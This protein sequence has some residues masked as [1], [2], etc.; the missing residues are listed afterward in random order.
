MLDINP[1]DIIF[2]KINELLE[3]YY[4]YDSNV[5]MTTKTDSIGKISQDIEKVMQDIFKTAKEEVDK[6]EDSEEKNTL[7]ILGCKFLITDQERKSI[8]KN[9]RP[10]E[11]IN[12]SQISNK[13]NT[14]DAIEI[15]EIIQPKIYSIKS[16]MEYY[17]NCI[18]KTQMIPAFIRY[19][20]INK[21]KDDE[22]KATKILAELYNL[23]KIIDEHNF[24][25]VSP[26]LEEYQKSFEIMFSKLKNSGVDFSKDPE[27]KKLTCNSNNQIQDFIILPEK[28]NFIIRP[29]NFETSQAEQTYTSNITTKRSNILIYNK[30]GIQSLQDPSMMNLEYEKLGPVSQKKTK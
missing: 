14:V 1:Q 11:K 6:K 5:K 2:Y 15:D 25:L 16:I 26:R 22:Q 30:T 12:F 29:N 23:Y 27:L 7:P 10:I 28:D 8:D 17:G 4:S 9:V 24:S 18:L 20:V 3:K 21:N 19:A 13:S